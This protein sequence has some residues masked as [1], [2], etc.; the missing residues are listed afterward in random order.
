VCAPYFFHIC[1]S[2]SYVLIELSEMNVCD[3]KGMHTQICEVNF[4]LA[5][6]RHPNTHIHTHIFFIAFN[7]HL[8]HG[9]DG[10]GRNDTVRK[11][12]VNKKSR[13][14]KGR[15]ERGHR[16][17]YNCMQPFFSPRTLCDGERDREC[18]SQHEVERR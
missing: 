9:D 10:M 8:K 6:P 11:N 2:L 18:V 3:E 17:L 16:K 13:Q 7:L 5:S 4:G 12:V 1:L 15:P 14:I